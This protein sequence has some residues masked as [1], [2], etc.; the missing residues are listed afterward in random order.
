MDLRY[1]NEH[2]RA[3]IDRADFGVLEGDSQIVK[4]IKSRMHRH[5]DRM[6]ELEEKIEE[7]DREIKAERAMLKDLAVSWD[8]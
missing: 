1:N 4:D 7:A 8:V 5:L 2:I 3:E 6:E